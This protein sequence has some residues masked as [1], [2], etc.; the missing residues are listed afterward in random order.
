MPLMTN[1][2]TLIIMI[3]TAASE[4]KTRIGAVRMRQMA[5]PSTPLCVK[6]SSVNKLLKAME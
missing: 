6:L 1:R 2:K 4:T 3:V 5:M